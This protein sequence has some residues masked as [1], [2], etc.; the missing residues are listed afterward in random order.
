MVLVRDRGFQAGRTGGRGLMNY[1]AKNQTAWEARRAAVAEAK[2]RAEAALAAER[3]VENN[4]SYSVPAFR[5]EL[6]EVERGVALILLLEP[7]AKAKISRTRTLPTATTALCTTPIN[8]QHPQPPPSQ[9]AVKEPLVADAPIGLPP[10]MVPSSSSPA[11]P[12]NN[13]NDPRSAEDLAF[14]AFLARAQLSSRRHIEDRRE[15]LQ[16]NVDPEGERAALHDILDTIVTDRP[17]SA[18]STDTRIVAT[19]RRLQPL[20]DRSSAGEVRRH[21]LYH[22]TRTGVS[23]DDT[24]ITLQVGVLQR[25]KPRVENIVELS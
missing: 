2:L 15:D 12:H 8:H 25:P 3:F 4:V 24:K 14:E 9:A 5:R 6:D 21:G 23:A 19:T 1:S 18:A 7:K 22:G 17:S 11:L 16:A 20:A 10:V 13:D